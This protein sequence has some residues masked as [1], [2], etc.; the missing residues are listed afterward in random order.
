MPARICKHPGCGRTTRE[1]YCDRHTARQAGEKNSAERGYWSDWRRLRGDGTHGFVARWIAEHGP[2]CAICRKP[3]RGGRQTH[4]D[5]IVPFDGVDDPK[6]LDET[7]LQLLCD[8]CNSE[9][10]KRDN[11]HDRQ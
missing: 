11:G 10:A 8:G 6:R 9:K 7:N 1:R 4:V 3:L 5:H 2:W